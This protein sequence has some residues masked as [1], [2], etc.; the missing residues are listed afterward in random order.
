[1][2]FTFTESD[3]LTAKFSSTD[4]FRTEFES[5]IANDNY[6]GEYNVTPSDERQ[7]LPTNGKVMLDDVTIDAVEA[8]SDTQ[9]RAAV[10]EGWV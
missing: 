1:M 4:E 9:I 6:R 5:I 3:N 8:L 7:T 2:I 10:T